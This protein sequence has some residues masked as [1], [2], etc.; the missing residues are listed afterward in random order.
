[1][2]EVIELHTDAS[3]VCLGA[4]LMQA[5]KEGDPLHLV[6][7]EAESRYLSSKLELMCIVW[8]HR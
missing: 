3:V 7:C 6:Y 5:S 8:V 2:F 4:I 1:M